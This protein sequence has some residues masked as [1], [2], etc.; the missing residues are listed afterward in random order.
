M[1]S[2]GEG[3]VRTL[4][5]VNALRGKEEEVKA[6]LLDLVQL[7]QQSSSCLEADLFRGSPVGQEFLIVSDWSTEMA[8]YSVLNSED[9]N[10]IWYE[11]S[12]LLAS[13]PEINYYLPIL[14]PTDDKPLG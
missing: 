7:L 12:D 2:L 13:A 14:S 5:L 10:Q 3:G 9:V 4:I 6:K 8:M 11:E 1:G